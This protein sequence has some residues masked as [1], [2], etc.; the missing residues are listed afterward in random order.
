MS[1]FFHVGLRR[2]WAALLVIAVGAAASAG[3]EEPISSAMLNAG[4]EFETAYFTQRAAAAGPTVVVVGGMH[5]NE[6]AGAYA[7]EQIRFWPIRRGTIVVVPRANPPAL[8]VNKRYT[9]GVAS[10]E[11]NL[12]RNFPRAGK[13][14]APRGA[15]AT[16]LW[17]LIEGLKPDWVVDLHE[18]YDFHQINDDSVGS[19]VIAAR[20]PE[21]Q[22]VAELLL[23]RINPVIADD[24]K[25]FVRLGP[26][27]DGS[28]ARAAAEHLGCRSFI[29]ETTSGGQPLPLRA[30][31]HRLMMHTLLSHLGMLDETLTSDSLVTSLT[32]QD[33]KHIAIFQDKGVA[34]KGVP[35][36]EKHLGGR[37]DLRLIQVCGEDIRAGMLDQFDAVIFSGGS[38]SGQAAALDEAGRE[39][40]R[41]FIDQGGAYVGICAGAYL[42]CNGFSWGLKVLDAKTVSP[43]WRRGAGQVDVELTTLGRRMLRGEDQPVS[44]R[45]VNGPILAPDGAEEIPD[46][47]VLAWFRSELAENNT[48]R[49]VMI[50]SPAIVAGDFGQGRVFCFSPHPEQT[51]GCE[52]F[53]WEALE[54]HLFP[55]P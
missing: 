6:P 43:A 35:Q 25:D 4:T 27:V 22:A 53:V 19:S 30:R 40:V 14:E 18:G 36:L 5:G 9:P 54:E 47:E 32:P 7:A 3:A 1:R 39:A 16:A 42:A 49:G 2:P 10:T 20:D 28:L 48:P 38:G 52:H 55:A 46:F 29:L 24:R 31:Q 45:Y 41:R 51:P 17:G 15:M 33:V 11:S 37:A 44:V 23:D 21:S 13:T 26:P 12:N 50:N 8:A 34:G